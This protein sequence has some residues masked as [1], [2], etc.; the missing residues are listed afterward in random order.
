MSSAF[1]RRNNSYSRSFSASAAESE[2]RYPLTR[3]ASY[4]RLS[5]AAFKKGLDHANITTSEWH[6]VGKYANKVDYYDVSDS[7]EIANAY[8]FWKGAKNKA[9]GNIC[10]TAIKNIAR[11]NMLEKTS[12]SFEV[13][14][15]S[16][17][18]S[19]ISL[20][21]PMTDKAMWRAVR[22][23]LADKKYSDMQA[24]TK[25]CPIKVALFENGYVMYCDGIPRCFSIDLND[26]TYSNSSSSGK[27]HYF[28]KK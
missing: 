2:N 15:R 11:A 18:R 28:I 4:L 20:P 22:K 26:Y 23:A 25:A 17:D 14:S 5:V 24:I 3:A 9:N 10:L 27:T 7:G 6:H 16:Y 19:Y 21:Q 13:P 12:P 8:K 1:Y